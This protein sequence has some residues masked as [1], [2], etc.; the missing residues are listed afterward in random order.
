MKNIILSCA[1]ALSC[2]SWDGY[3][4]DKG[5]FVEIWKGNLARSGRDIEIY[6]YSDGKYKD[7]EVQSITKGLGGKVEVEVYDYDKKEYRTFEMDGYED[8]KA[9]KYDYS[10]ELP[11]V[12]DYLN[13]TPSSNDYLNNGLGNEYDKPLGNW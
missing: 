13:N 9:K 11:G 7:V 2:F 1:V 8:R 10:Y 3:D 5:S 6:D 12:N 4:Y